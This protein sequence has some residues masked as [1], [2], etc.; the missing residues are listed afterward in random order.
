MT[1]TELYLIQALNQKYKASNNEPFVVA[2]LADK[3]GTLEANVWNHT[4]DDAGTCLGMKAG[5]VYEVSIQ[6]SEYK[7]KL[8]GKLN[9]FSH[10]KIKFDEKDFFK[11]SD[12][13]P[14]QMWTDFQKYLTGFESETFKS[15][16]ASLFDAEST[17]LFRKAPAA[18][19]MH[20]AFLH[21][22]LEHTLQM[23]QICE[24]LLEFPFFKKPLNKDLCMFGVMFHDFGKIY[25]YSTEPG[26]KKRL[27]G[28]L[29][30]HIPMVAARILETCNKLGVPEEVRDHMMHV[31]L[32]HHRFK[33]WGS[34]MTFACP[35][36]AFIHYIDNLHGDV[37]GIIQKRETATN[38][39]VVYGFDEDRTTILKTPFNDVMKAVEGIP[40]GF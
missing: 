7:E 32:S 23:L 15:V 40:D 30:G 31:V 11:T 29:V 16:A 36:A 18:T 21:G 10:P 2:V 19:G 14:E 9:G 13:D 33:R 4:L 39:T 28:I 8:S 24:K 3:T 1:V 22:L 12:Y 20:H 34:P 27:Q 26:F 25:E 6:V 37:F 35:E 5:A 38:D 17:E